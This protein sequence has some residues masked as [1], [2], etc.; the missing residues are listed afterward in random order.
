MRPTNICRQ[1]FS[2]PP[3]TASRYCDIIGSGGQAGILKMLILALLCYSRGTR[4]MNSRTLPINLDPCAAFGAPTSERV[5][6]RLK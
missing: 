3:S 1:A 6:G 5:A 4:C 2:S